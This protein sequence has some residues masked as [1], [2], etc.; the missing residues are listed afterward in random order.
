ME[1]QVLDILLE[2]Q[3]ERD[4]YTLTAMNNVAESLS[5]L[6]MLAEAEAMY[7][8]LVPLSRDM[9]GPNHP[10]LGTRLNNFGLAL[11]RQGKLA[12]AEPIEREALS[13]AENGNGDPMNL[14]RTLD[15]LA[16]TID[17][18]DRVSEANIL[19]NRSDAIWIDLVCPNADAKSGRARYGGAACPGH[20]D[21]MSHAGHR[22]AFRIA[23]QDRATAAVRA[24]VNSSDMVLGRT[25]LNYRLDT[26]ARLEYRQ[27]QPVHHDLISS[28][29]AASHPQ[30]AQ[31]IGVAIRNRYRLPGT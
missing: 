7:R 30:D 10:D 22:A 31:S 1:Q 29:W 9:L 24:F 28:A 11:Q 18:L 25:R 26:A 8:Q 20:P 3:G 21:H 23:R 5:S 2:T 27:F 13:I 14:A 16:T 6:R 4:R 12:E 17:A 15:N 19:L